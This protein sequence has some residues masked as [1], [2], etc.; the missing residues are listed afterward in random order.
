[1]PAE[2]SPLGQ[3][4][5][6]VVGGAGHAGAPLAIVLANSGFRV[7]AYD[8][9]RPMVDRFSRGEMPYRE[10]GGAEALRSALD[11]ERLAF[12]SEGSAIAGIPNVII[13]IGAA[14]GERESSIAEL[15][16][17]CVDEIALQLEDGACIVVRTTVPPGTTKAVDHHLRERGRS[18]LVA[19]CPE[20]VAQG[21]AIDEMGTI[22]QIVSGMS[23]SAVRRARDI[24]KRV[25][26]EIV[27]MT[28]LEAE[29][30]KL[31]CN[32]HRYIQF[33]AANALG[34]LVESAGLN[35]NDLLAR[36][37]RGYPRME[38]AP[39][40]G[41]AG[42]PCLAKDTRQLVASAPGAF[43]LGEVALTVNEGMPHYIVSKLLQ[44]GKIDGKHVGILGVAFKAGSDDIRNSLAFR[45]GELLADCGARVHYSDEYVRDASL[46]PKEALI[47]ESDVIVI[48]VPH[49]AYKTV[50]I[51]ADK[52]VVDLSGCRRG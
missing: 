44:R 17:A 50:A 37:K 23:P 12:T 1:M 20:R 21:N 43:A 16:L 3:A 52:I 29:Y 33:A 41:F 40:A 35:Y 22:A 11:A 4:D 6:C 30:S 14:D 8:V 38:H 51:P 19:F 39:R 32:A 5:I 2:P 26:P 28:P 36:T 45:L 15:L 42:G 9:D 46:E 31:I 27:E 49:D 48:A 34:M 24:F 25:A 47:V 18:L 13:A 7:L 10:T